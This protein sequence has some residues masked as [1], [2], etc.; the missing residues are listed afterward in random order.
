MD[1]FT[2]CLT[3][4]VNSLEL[5]TNPAYVLYLYVH[6][7]GFIVYFF[8]IVGCGASLMYISTFLVISQNFK[9]HKT[10]AF[11]FSN[12]GYSVGIFI[13]PIL[14]DIAILEYSLFGYLLIFGGFMLNTIVCTLLFQLPNEMTDKKII[15]QR[16]QIL[17][18][19]VLGQK[20][21]N[22]EGM[23]NGVTQSQNSLH[24]K[25]PRKGIEHTSMDLA[26]SFGSIKMDDFGSAIL[27]H[28]NQEMM[29]RA[30][31]DISRRRTVSD[32]LTTIKQRRTVPRPIYKPSRMDCFEEESVKDFLDDM[33]NKTNRKQS[34]FVFLMKKPLFIFMCFFTVCQSQ[35]FAIFYS[36]VKAMAQESGVRNDQATLLLSLSG[37]TDLFGN[38]ILPPLLDSHLLK[39]HQPGVYSLLTL[40]TSATFVLSPLVGGWPG[41]AVT[42]GI[43]AFFSSQLHTMRIPILLQIVKLEEESFP[44]AVGY[45]T[46]ALGSGYVVGPTIGG[47]YQKLKNLNNNRN[48]NINQAP[49][50]ST[51]VGV[52][53][54]F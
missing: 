20:R 30:S 10:L 22:F 21:P 14:S 4:V 6:V 18:K 33:D 53:Q 36:F 42:I 27:F 5:H 48:W 51:L 2:N 7:F 31:S 8:N 44:T 29:S 45:L 26:T 3:I 34:I 9:H 35:I 49:V 52:L 50:F 11:G 17:Q 23:S 47:T 46:F 54:K 12:I 39:K 16:K 37:L 40:V 24:E 38:L 19:R 15:L 25:Q 28:Q 43:F 32:S 13:F 41:I 1:L